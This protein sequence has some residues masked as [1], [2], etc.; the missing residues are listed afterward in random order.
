MKQ[1]AASRRNG[2]VGNS[3]KNIPMV[4]RPTEIIPVVMRSIR[5]MVSNIQYLIQIGINKNL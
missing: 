4:H 3:V 2:V 5:I 1:A